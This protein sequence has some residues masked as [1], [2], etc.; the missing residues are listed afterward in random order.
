MVI[1]KDQTKVLVVWMEHGGNSA[2][3][4][5]DSRHILKVEL[6]GLADDW[7]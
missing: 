6:P 2:E 1:A 4:Q 5:T 7:M 3:K